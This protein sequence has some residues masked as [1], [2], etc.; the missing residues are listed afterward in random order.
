MTLPFSVFE[1]HLRLSVRL[2][3][4]G[5][6]DAFDGVEVAADGTLWLKARVSQPPEGGKA[7]KALIA[8]LSKTFRLPKSAI[9][10]MS[11]ETARKKILRIEADPEDFE[12]T[13]KRLMND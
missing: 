10:L 13:F 5:G 6:R 2:T 4:S 12:I 8:L 9:T 11:G 1:D 7:N 3:P